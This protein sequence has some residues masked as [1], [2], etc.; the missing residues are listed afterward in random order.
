MEGQH[1]K[2]FLTGPTVEAASTLWLNLRAFLCK[3]GLFLV[4]LENMSLH[5]E[6]PLQSGAVK[7]WGMNGKVGRWEDGWIPRWK[8][9]TEC[10]R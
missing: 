4:S 1:P 2:L 6:R 7:V 8:D 3:S 10:I 9:E 5:I